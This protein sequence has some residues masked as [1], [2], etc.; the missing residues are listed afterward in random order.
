[1]YL[2]H[3]QS[4][5]R[6]V[7]PATTSSNGQTVTNNSSWPRFV[8]RKST[9]RKPPVFPVLRAFVCVRHVFHS[10]PTAIIA[11]AFSEINMP[12]LGISIDFFAICHKFVAKSSFHNSINFWKANK[13]KGVRRYLLLLFQT[14]QI[15]FRI[16]T[17]FAHIYFL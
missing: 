16:R 14:F 17:Q 10:L 1:M 3:S 4:L 12:D 5:L 7:Q 2:F 11:Y 9:K 6:L 13:I 15:S 8:H